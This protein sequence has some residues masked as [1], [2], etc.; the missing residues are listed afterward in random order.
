MLYSVQGSH[1]DCLSDRDES[2][3][4]FYATE[5]M[6]ELVTEPRFD[7]RYFTIQTLYIYMYPANINVHN[8]GLGL[9][10]R[11]LIGKLHCSSIAS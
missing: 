7:D 6:T 5:L 11:L 9:S 2:G 1:W 4:A 3:I 10:A 8:Q